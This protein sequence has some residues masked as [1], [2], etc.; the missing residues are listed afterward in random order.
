MNETR[1]YRWVLKS[2]KTQL[3][4]KEWVIS[5]NGEVYDGCSLAHG[6]VIK[7]KINNTICTLWSTGYSD[8][9]FIKVMKMFKESSYRSGD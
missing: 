4:L 7:F 2:K 8:K 5:N 9:S 1:Y 6:E 3:E